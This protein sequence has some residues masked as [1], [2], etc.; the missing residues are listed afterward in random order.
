MIKTSL[1]YITDIFL[2][3]FLLMKNIKTKLII[4]PKYKKL[5]FFVAILECFQKFLFFLFGQVLI[6]FFFIYLKKH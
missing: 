2:N 3:N 4:N 1:S 5:K 6:N